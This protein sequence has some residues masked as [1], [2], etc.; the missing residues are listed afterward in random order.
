MHRS[1]FYLLFCVGENLVFRLWALENKVAGRQKDKGLENI[2]QSIAYSTKKFLMTK[3]TRTRCA[4]HVTY[5]NKCD[6]LLKSP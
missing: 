4:T 6:I 2:T 5:M 3:L 1:V